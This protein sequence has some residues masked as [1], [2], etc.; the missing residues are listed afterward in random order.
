MS[1]REA[2]D[3]AGMTLDD[4]LVGVRQLPEAFWMSRATI[5]RLDSKDHYNAGDTVR[6]IALAEVFDC[7]LSDIDPEAAAIT[8]ALNG[9]LARRTGGDPGSVCNLGVTESDNRVVA[10]V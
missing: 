10:T 2:R 5:A 6:L 1:V 9:L 3:K 4:V 8:D 7:K